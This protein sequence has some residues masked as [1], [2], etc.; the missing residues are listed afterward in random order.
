MNK[1]TKE[2]NREFLFTYRYGGAEWGI[3]IFAADAAEAREKIKAV[4]LARYD[5]ELMMTIPAGV[6]LF[7][8]VPSLICWL[9]NRKWLGVR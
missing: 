4:A 6:G 1:Q 7:G 8:I 3:S 9:R 5:G 2:A